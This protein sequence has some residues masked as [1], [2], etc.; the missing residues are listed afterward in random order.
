[1]KESR[2]AGTC[3]LQAG[4]VFLP[5]FVERYNERFFVRAAWVQFLIVLPSG[6]AKDIGQLVRQAYCICG[7][8]VRQWPRRMI[9]I[10]SKPLMFAATIFMFWKPRVARVGRVTRLSAP[11]STLTTLP[12]YSQG[13]M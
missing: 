8:Q 6:D 4:N 9:R 10:T 5:D 1:M 2:L 13:A 7:L 3:A 11:W 12:K